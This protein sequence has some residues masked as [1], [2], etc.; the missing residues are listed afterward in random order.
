MYD[1]AVQTYNWTSTSPE[2]GATYYACPGDTVTLPWSLVTTSSETVN[3]VE[4][5]FAEGGGNNTLIASYIQG[6]LLLSHSER[7]H[8]AFVPNAG[9]KVSDIAPEDFGQYS[10]RLVINSN[11]SFATKGG[12]VFVRLPEPPAVSDR[13]L[14]ARILPSAVQESGQWHVQ[15]SCGRF[16]SRGS[17]KFSVRWKTPSGQVLNSTYSETREDILTLP[18]PVEEGNYSCFL[19]VQDPTAKCAFVSPTMMTSS[20]LHINSCSV[21]QALFNPVQQEKEEM[22]SAFKF[23]I[24][25]RDTVRLVNGNR[26]WKGRVEVKYNRTWGAVCD[27]DFSALSAAVVC[28]MLGL[29]GQV[30]PLAIEAY[31]WTS[32]SPTNN[33]VYYSCVGDAVTLSWS[34]TLTSVESVSDIEWYFTGTGGNT[35]LIASYIQGELLLSHSAPQPLTFVSNAGLRVSNIR[36]DDFGQYSVRVVINRNSSFATETGYVYVRAPDPPTVADRMLHVRM[37]PSAVRRESGDWH[38]QLACGNVTSRGSL[39]VSVKWR[40][41][42]GLTLGSSFTENGE[43]ILNV[44][45][46][47]EGNYSCFLDIDDSTAR[48]VDISPAMLVSNEVHVDTCSVKPPLSN[49]V[50]REKREMESVFQYLARQ[51]DTIR[52]VNGSRPWNGRVEVKYN[53][54]WAVVCDDLFSVWSATVVCTMLGVTG[55]VIVSYTIID[56][57]TTSSACAV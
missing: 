40:T 33:T 49:L 31:T 37:L 53:G 7:Q 12:Y 25:V 30:L 18:N 28:G 56:L 55:Q 22:E 20:N 41:P 3:D 46:A 54:S 1:E 38:V 19:D 29:S 47:E 45:P 26:P 21:Q 32:R 36:P 48:C 44:S 9:L 2:L 52:L 39:N 11:S 14:R 35:T 51:H 34:F 50:Q 27:T 8:L 57:A 24:R 15:L 43:E 10:V 16:N 17:L 42:S 23:L 5:Y 4:W 13:L 6:E